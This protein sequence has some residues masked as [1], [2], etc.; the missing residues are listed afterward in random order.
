MGEGLRWAKV[1]RPSPICPFDKLRTPL[2]QETFGDQKRVQALTRFNG[3]R[4]VRRAIHCS[5]SAIK[6]FPI[7]LGQET[8][9]D[10]S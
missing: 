5:S 10:Q 8:F 6:V 3:F 9:G 1:S 2:G 7:R 4:S